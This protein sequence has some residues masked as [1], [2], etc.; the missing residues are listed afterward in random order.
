M[1]TVAEARAAYAAGAD[2]LVVQG[3][4]AG[5]HRGGWTD[6]DDGDVPLA[7]A[8]PRHRLRRSRCRSSRPA[9]S[10]T[11]TAFAPHSRQA[12]PRRR[13][14]PRS[15]SARRRARASRTGGRS[16]PAARPAFTRAFTGR[17]AR[18]LVNAF[19][20]AHPDA[21]SA[22]PQIHHLTAPLRAAARAAG[23]AD[24]I[25]LWAGTNAALAR[26]EPAAEIV[27]R[28]RP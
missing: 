7:R 28:L 13:S 23:D 11:A 25:N 4:E 5:G 12:Q 26:A 20:R 6:S 9:G 21:P 17:R 8:R 10:P 14:A 1:T 24:G 22:Y 16:P 15:S 27:A 18:G 19:M 2:A 3:A